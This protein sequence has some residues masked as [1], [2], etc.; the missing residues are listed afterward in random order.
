M[1]RAPR[2]DTASSRLATIHLGLILTLGGLALT[3][4]NVARVD[5]LEPA[6]H[7]FSPVLFTQLLSFH[8]V[9]LWHSAQRRLRRPR[10]GSSWQLSQRRSM[11]L[12]AR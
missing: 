4:V 10:C 9:V 11:R 5:F 7:V 3:A 1:S 8:E 2:F 6:A 12:S